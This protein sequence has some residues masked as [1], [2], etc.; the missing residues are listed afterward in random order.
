MATRQLFLDLHDAPPAPFVPAPSITE[1][2]AHIDDPE[3]RRLAE[4]VESDRDGIRALLQQVFSGVG[5]TSFEQRQQAGVLLTQMNTLS[6]LE[7]GKGVLQLQVRHRATRLHMKHV[8][9]NGN[10]RKAGRHLPYAVPT[11]DAEVAEK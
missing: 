2:C 7:L 1:R 5:A 10:L 11:D 4:Q 3:D 6:P 9:T 8:V